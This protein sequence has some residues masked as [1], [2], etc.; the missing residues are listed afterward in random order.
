MLGQ[1]LAGLRIVW[2]SSQATYLSG[3]IISCRGLGRQT[4][5]EEQG[6]IRRETLGAPC[7]PHTSPQIFI[8]ILQLALKPLGGSMELV[9]KRWPE[10]PG[11]RFPLQTLVT[12]PR[13]IQISLWGP[14]P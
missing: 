10:A 13:A 7:H 4:D 2:S 6:R 5:R 14:F 1:G 8:L 9:R 12:P 3:F 11:L